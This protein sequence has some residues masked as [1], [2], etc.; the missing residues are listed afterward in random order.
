MFLEAY[1]YNLLMVLLVAPAGAGVMAAM[2]LLTTPWREVLKGWCYL[3]GGFVA[4]GALAMLP[5]LLTGDRAGLVRS[6]CAGA[7]YGYSCH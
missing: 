2:A 7:P 3:T 4:I 6:D 5:S 1:L